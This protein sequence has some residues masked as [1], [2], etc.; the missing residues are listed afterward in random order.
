MK[1]YILIAAGVVGFVLML[2]CIWLGVG[3]ED[4]PKHPVLCFAGVF[5][6]YA[7]GTL[8]LAAASSAG[9]A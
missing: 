4:E 6:G 7:L 3:R 9:T 1:T 8:A 5:F 2:T